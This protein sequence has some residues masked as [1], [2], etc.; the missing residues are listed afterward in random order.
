MQCNDDIPFFSQQLQVCL[1]GE[2][3]VQ[4]GTGWYNTPMFMDVESI[5][6]HPDD[7]IPL[8]RRNSLPF[9]KTISEAIEDT[10]PAKCAKVV[11][12]LMTSKSTDCIALMD[13]MASLSPV[14]QQKQTAEL[15]LSAEV[16]TRLNL[17]DREVPAFVPPEAHSAHTVH[18]RYSDEDIPRLTKVRLTV[19]RHQMEHG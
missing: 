10:D 16:A 13:K 19:R 9:C 8:S 14:F 11:N 17:V 18:T 4:P 2:M 6:I 5:F 1:H 12:Y 15:D 3:C 7:C